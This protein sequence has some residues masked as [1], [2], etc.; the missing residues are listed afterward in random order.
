[1]VIFVHNPTRRFQTPPRPSETAPS[2][3]S[4]SLT[5]ESSSGSS[6]PAQIGL[7]SMQIGLFAEQIGLREALR[8]SHRSRST[9]RG[10]T[11]RARVSRAALQIEPAE[12]SAGG[13]SRQG[14]V[15][16]A[17]PSA[18]LPRRRLG[19]KLA[20]PPAASSR[21]LA[22]SVASAPPPWPRPAHCARLPRP[23]SRPLRAASLRR[24]RKRAQRVHLVAFG[25]A[26]PIEATEKQRS[27][28]RGG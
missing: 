18:R 4:G 26:Q 25:T 10:D 17:A 5:A 11:I 3:T 16:G 20:K 2:C 27:R 1:M 6:S 15:E 22:P 23:A 12:T 19:G 28:D 7:F 8:Y 21:R 13:S 9:C 24:R 14:R